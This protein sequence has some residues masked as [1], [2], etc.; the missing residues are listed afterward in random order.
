LLKVAVIAPSDFAASGGSFS[1]IEN[2]T[3]EL[4]RL[5]SYPGLRFTI[6][7][8]NISLLPKQDLNSTILFREIPSNG[9]LKTALLVY[10]ELRSFQSLSLKFL[11]H[12]FP[13]RSNLRR[14]LEME[15][16]DFIWS[17][18]PSGEAFDIPFA[19]TIWDLEFRRQPFFPEVSIFGEW[20]KRQIV[21]I[22]V[23]QRASLI[24]VGTNFG[25]QQIQ[26]YFNIDESRILIVPFSIRNQSISTGE[27]RNPDLIF[28]PAQFWPH[29]NHVTLI[30]AMKIVTLKTGRKLKL[31]LPG[32]DKGNLE[33]VK[34]YAE[35]LDLV[36]VI[37]FPGFI[38]DTELAHLYRTA[39]LMVYASV[40][41]PDNLP[42]LEA[43]ASGCPVLV[44][45]NPGAREQLGESVG[46]FSPLSEIDLAEKII[47]NLENQ[48]NIKDVSLPDPADSLKSVLAWISQFEPYVRMWKFKHEST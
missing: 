44:A 33:V 20:E 9:K 38:S 25:S 31:V 27:L 37:E 32:S 4:I 45:E 1:Y 34:R 35:D 16:F 43:L 41:G 5:K 22:Q 30:K 48:Q 2:L 46:Y 21:N 15:D 3:K 23:L 14:T 17:L 13:K 18:A 39:G 47:M 40:F 10:K 24:I 12:L 11:A 8:K 19:T 6:F 28:Y 36:D 29:K 26:R 7:S 42:P